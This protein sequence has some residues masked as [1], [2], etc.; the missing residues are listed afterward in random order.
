MPK[1]SVISAAFNMERVFSFRASVDSILNQSFFDF[2]FI[3]CD[4]GSCDN[5]YRILCEYA[6]R[7]GRIRVFRNPEQKGL[8]YSLNRCLEY[9]SAP[10]VARH[11]LDDISHRER[12]LRQYL[13]LRKNPEISVLGTAVT[14]F[15]RKGEFSH[16]H[17]PKSVRAEDF[18]FSSPYMHG[19]VMMRRETLLSVGGY[20]VSKITRRTEDYELF[21]RLALISS[22]ANLEE[23]LYYYLEDG[24]TRRRR[25]YKYRI[26]EMIVRARGF[27]SLG[28][29]PRAL[30]YVVKPL[31]VGLIPSL[32]LENLK[33][34]REEKRYG[35]GE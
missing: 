12:L 22:G 35:A 26:D 18:L 6:A 8:A 9:A 28:L 27:R 16:R 21:M 19:S 1:I 17:F 32:L 11:D 33:R 23:R 5:T 31:I 10:I 34:R 4:D 7:D 14:L 15:N 3:I 24:D 29:M 20:K 25:K 2:E 30:P 13:Y